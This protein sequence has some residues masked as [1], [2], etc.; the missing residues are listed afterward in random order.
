MAYGAHEGLDWGRPHF[1]DVVNHLRDLLRTRDLRIGS[2]D[3]R[4]PPQPGGGEGAE[5]YPQDSPP[6]LGEVA[7]SG[8]FQQQ[9]EAAPA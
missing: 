1:A 8:R 4:Y 2:D 3:G 9:P 6:G 5:R 7:L